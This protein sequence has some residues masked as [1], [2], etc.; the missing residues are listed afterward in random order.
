MQADVDDEEVFGSLLREAARAKP[1]QKRN[2]TRKTKAPPA[3]VPDMPTTVV[4]RSDAQERMAARVASP[5]RLLEKDMPAGFTMKQVEGFVSAVR[6]GAHLDD[7]ARFMRIRPAVIAMWMGRG[8]REETGWFHHFFEEVEQARGVLGVQ[9]SVN[10][11]KAGAMP[12][13]WR[14]AA[15]MGARRLPHAFPEEKAGDVNVQVVN[16][17]L[18][19]ERQAALRTVPLVRLQRIIEKLPAE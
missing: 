16:T 1:A 15:Y 5:L 14:A 19:P 10:I 13:Q 12:A 11:M 3:I 17:Q 7:A 18:S 6:G 9:L 8:E 4:A 2:A